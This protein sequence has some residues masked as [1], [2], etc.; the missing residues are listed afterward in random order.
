LL[1]IIYTAANILLGA[2]GQVKLADFGV[3]GQLSQTMTKKNTF[4]GTPFWMAPEV[5]KQS[6]YDHKADI[7]SLGITALELANGEPP[8]SEIHP[9]KVLFLIPKN[10]APTLEGDFSSAFKDFVGQC[11]RKEPRERPGA[12]ELL[13]HPFVKRAKK[14]TYLTE[15]IERHERYQIQHGKDQDE[16]EDERPM[17]EKRH[18]E[19][20]DLWDFGTIKPVNGRLPGLKTLNDAAANARS[21]TT[22]PVEAP[23]P[24]KQVQQPPGIENLPTPGRRLPSGNTIRAK[25]LPPPPAIT[26]L[27]K[28]M[29]D[30]LSSPTLAA[31][32]PLPPS[33]Q[34]Q[35]IMA[36]RP[37]L[38]SAA[39]HPKAQPR[40]FSF[41]R[42]PPFLQRPNGALE[43]NMRDMRLTTPTKSSSSSSQLA[44]AFDPNQ[45]P[46]SH[47]SQTP[48]QS[49]PLKSQQPLPTFSYMPGNAHHT[50]PRTPIRPG[51]GPVQQVR[52]SSIVAVRP[53]PD[54]QPYTGTPMVQPR[55][56]FESKPLEYATNDVHA[57]STMNANRQVQTQSDITALDSV[58]VPALES[59]LTRRSYALNGI[60]ARPD[61]RQQDRQKLQNAHDRIRNL[62]TKVART[63]AEVDELDLAAPVNLDGDVGSFLEGFLEEILVRVEAE[64]P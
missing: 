16:T 54:A 53:S 4:V 12:K 51:Q 18:T 6:G 20:E 58:I 8:Y 11:L 39:S 57:Q 10:A 33:P 48:H 43:N 50:G 13:K 61:L 2:N 37:N 25:N 5:I 42:T 15:L 36:S 22:S 9:M 46:R 3:S 24:R 17:P 52:Q 40:T 59:A 1:L 19:N 41:E 34:K 47:T 45:T 23:I 7:W 38:P 60:L 62:V 27:R 35:D 49:S 14:T 29:L 63:I 44:P 21:G 32:V 31:K 26:P 56:Q 55:P 64:D 28:P 30:P